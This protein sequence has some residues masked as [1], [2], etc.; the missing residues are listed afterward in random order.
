MRRAVVIVVVLLVIAC[1]LAAAIGGLAYLFHV[2]TAEARP[3]VLI[4]AP[5][6]GQ[7]A[8]V[9]E[10]ISVQAVAR[11][12]TKVTRVELWVDGVLETSQES[13]LPGGISPFPILATWQP[14]TSGTH[15]LIVRAFNSQNAHAHSSVTVDALEP[16]DADGDGEP[17]PGHH[18]RGVGLHRR[19]DEIARMLGGQ[20]ITDST[21]QHAEEMLLMAPGDDAAGLNRH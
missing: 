8:E 15:T 18:A 20:K 4:S 1:S 2:P 17:Q 19:V 3:M 10:A 21:L 12:E 9:G 14:L 5:A 6:H 13:I 11:D 16:L 7:Q